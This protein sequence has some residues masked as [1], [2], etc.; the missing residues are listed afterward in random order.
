MAFRRGFKSEANDIVVEVRQELRLSL[1][2]PL[3]PYVL[4]AWLEIPIIGLSDL[5][6]DAPAIAHLLRIE[7]EVFSAATVFAGSQRAIVHNDAHAR[8]RQ[9]SNLSHELAH[10]LLLHPPTPALDNN[11]CRHWNQDLEDEANWLCGALLVPEAATM[12]LAKGR[13]STHA[14]AACHFGVS[15]Q[16]IRYRLNATGALIRIQRAHNAKMARVRR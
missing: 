7:P 1:Y 15:E 11:G 16:M 12:L 2:D 3:D 4:A 9:I 10:A 8:V 6:D 14:D 13:W 5:V